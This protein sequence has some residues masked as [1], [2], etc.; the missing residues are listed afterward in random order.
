MELG[1]E[2][3]LA[4]LF[5]SPLH[6]ATRQI[7]LYMEVRMR[8]LDVSPREGHLLSYLRSYAPAPVSELARVFGLKSSTLTSMLDRL[9][10][11]R[12]I[13][14]VSNPR[15]RRSY[16]VKLTR[17]GHRL[18]ER[19]QGIVEALEAEL[20]RNV[21]RRELQGFQAV[22]AAVER[23]TNITVRERREE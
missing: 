4:L 18:A 2:V 12:F 8:D 16:L 11:G 13:L 14:R 21:N 17:S 10:K 22:M 9:E 20:R 1:E 5:L 6:K 7:G 3:N 19:V 23:V 15:D